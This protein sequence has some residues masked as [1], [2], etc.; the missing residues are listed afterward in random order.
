ML[1]VLLS[2]LSSFALFANAGDVFVC[3]RHHADF[4]YR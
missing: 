2:I 4:Q 3:C 1:T